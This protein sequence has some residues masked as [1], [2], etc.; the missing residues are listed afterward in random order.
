MT[1]GASTME[2]WGMTWPSVSVTA[3][4]HWA[5]DML[6]V[7]RPPIRDVTGAI[8]AARVHDWRSV[9]T[10]GDADTRVAEALAEL[11]LD[12]PPLAVDI[13][14]IVRSFLAQFGTDEASLRV[15]VVNKA[16][17]PKFHCDNVRIRLVTTYHGPATEFVYTDG[18]EDIRRTPT[19][20]LV[21]L[22][23]HKHP[24]HADTIHHRS[25]AVPP[26]E[27]RL[28]VVLDI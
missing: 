13:A 28:C 18:P 26:G 11:N 15:E 21:F 25:P 7:K 24:N 17:C 23:G 5:N 14:F 9:V 1:L 4:D 22:K 3:F 10:A 6:I 2:T 12:C 19:G 27:K 16:S 20:A 8:T